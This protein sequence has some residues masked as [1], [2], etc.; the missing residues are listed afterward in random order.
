[1]NPILSSDELSYAGALRKIMGQ[2]IST[3]MG[4][5]L[6]ILGQPSTHSDFI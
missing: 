4:P 1:M 6:T 3:P 2:K 5:E